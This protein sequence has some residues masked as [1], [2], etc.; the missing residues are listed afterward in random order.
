MVGEEE[1]VM[2]SIHSWVRASRGGKGLALALIVACGGAVLAGDQRSRPPV[3]PPDVPGVAGPG[4][5]LRA[6]LTVRHRRVRQDGSPAG[7]DAPVVVLSLDRARVGGHWRTSL[8]LRS[9]EPA[10]VLALNG[11][12]DLENPFAITRMAFDD[13]GSA[14]RMFDRAGRL[15]AA[16]DRTARRLLEVP[17]RPRAGATDVDRVLAG[18]PGRAGGRDETTGGLLVE[19][20][21]LAGRRTALARQ[22]GAAAGRLRGLDRFVANA[23]DTTRELLVSPDT[24][25]PA[26][27]SVARSGHLVSRAVFEYTPFPGAR[28]LRRSVRA[29]REI[30]ASGGDRLLS[31][32]DLTN[33]TVDDGSQR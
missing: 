33:V 20:A 14:P 25:L 16:P 9:A 11:P 28:F 5:R 4:Y 32:V 27:V 3:G 29:E 22:F 1:P 12:R 21:G 31:M 13:D 7:P 15:V 17:G 18:L 6:D 2:P 24:A 23:G 10:R 30:P 19:A 26:E 8:A